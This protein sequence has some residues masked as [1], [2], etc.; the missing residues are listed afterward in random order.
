MTPVID[1]VR[2]LFMDLRTQKLR[3]FLTTFGIVWGT[4]SLSLLL[5]FGDGLYTQMRRSFAGLGDRIVIAWPSRTSLPFEGINKGRRILVTEEDL[6]L[7]RKESRLLLSI[8]PE[9]SSSF[10]VDIGKKTILVDISGVEPEFGEMR[11]LVPQKGGRFINHPDMDERRR[12]VFIGNDLARDMFGEEDPVGKTVKIFSSPFTVVGVL[13][14]KDQDSSY[15]GR[16]KDKAFIPASTFTAVTGAKYPDIL[17]YKAKSPD[18][19]QPLTEEIRGILGKKLHFDPTDKEAIQVWD[20]TE[21]FVFLDTFMG[22]FRLFLGIVGLMT[23]IVGGIGVSNIM[24]VVVEERTREIGIKMAL[25]ATPRYVLFQFLTE[26]VIITA[27]GG[28]IGLAISSGI[29]S[30][31][32]KAGLEEFV[33]VPVVTL[34]IAILTSSLLGFVGIMAGYFPAKDAA[35]KEP[36]IAMK[37]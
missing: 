27:L 36:A 14:K 31:F 5:A 4:V 16:D 10:K 13:V 21:M 8:S 17:I 26:A 33:G 9:Y 32:A 29:C 11:N 34:R 24:N 22:A 2:Q 25:G 3:T 15:S 28:A 7:V 6:D 20:T 19:N 37:F 30:L 12:V 18:M 1:A 23:L 35:S